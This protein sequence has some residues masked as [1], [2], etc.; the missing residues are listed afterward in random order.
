MPSSVSTAGT[1]VALSVC[2]ARACV[3]CGELRSL[4]CDGAMSDTCHGCGR[5]VLAQRVKVLLARRKQQAMMG[6]DAARHML[7]GDA[8]SRVAHDDDANPS[9]RHAHDPNADPNALVY[10]WRCP[11]KNGAWRA[12]SGETSLQAPALS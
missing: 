5:P 12:S 10:M 7:G 8:S 11:G 2:E 9:P 1:S 4:T 6:S 3:H